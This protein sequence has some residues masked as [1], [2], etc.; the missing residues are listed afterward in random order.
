[1]LEFL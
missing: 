1:M